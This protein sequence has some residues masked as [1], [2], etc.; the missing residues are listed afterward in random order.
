MGKCAVTERFPFVAADITSWK[1]LCRHTGPRHVRYF[2]GPLR[3]NTS[4]VATG[5][6]KY[7]DRL[8]LGRSG[9]LRLEK[10]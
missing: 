1:A 5:G 4:V 9:R 2:A 7:L 6:G 3:G 8:R 10:F